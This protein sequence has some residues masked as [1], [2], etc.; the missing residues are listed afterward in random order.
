MLIFVNR[1]AVPFQIKPTGP[2]T[3]SFQ[4]AASDSKLTTSDAAQF[5]FPIH[6]PT[7]SEMVASTG[8]LDGDNVMQQPIAHFSGDN[9]VATCGGLEVS[10][11][12]TIFQELTDAALYPRN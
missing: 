4:V 3:A 7:T 6:T 11:A 2:G 10:M 1:A 12:S 5:K 8:V 9:V